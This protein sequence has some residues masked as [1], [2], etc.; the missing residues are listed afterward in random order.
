MTPAVRQNRS[1]RQLSPPSIFSNSDMSRAMVFNPSA[2]SE[3]SNFGKPA[4]T[5]T[6]SLTRMQLAA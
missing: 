4:A 6:A 5:R 1:E 3:A 2:R